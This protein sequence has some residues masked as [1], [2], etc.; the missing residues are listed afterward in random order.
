MSKMVEIS[1]VQRG[2][3]YLLEIIIIFFQLEVNG[4]MQLK[5]AFYNEK[6][7]VWEYLVEPV[8]ENEYIKKWNLEL[9]VESQFYEELFFCRKNHIKKHQSV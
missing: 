8:L 6:I 1:K 9:Q 7:S 2:Q 5:L 3:T 4:K